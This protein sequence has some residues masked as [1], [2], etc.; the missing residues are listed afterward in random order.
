MILLFL[1]SLEAK[2]G[3]LFY[4]TP[5]RIYGHVHFISRQFGGR[6]WHG[7]TKN[8]GISDIDWNTQEQLNQY[9]GH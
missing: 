3:Q 8:N 6:S 7:D 4:I 1:L 2:L 9:S 5:R